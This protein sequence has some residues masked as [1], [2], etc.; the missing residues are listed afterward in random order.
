MTDFRRA[1]RRRLSSLTWSVL[2]FCTVPVALPQGV[3]GTDR[4]IGGVDAG[5]LVDRVNDAMGLR[6]SDVVT[7]KVDA[8][9]GE[10]FQVSLWIGGALRTLDLSPHSVR[11][12]D[13]YQV[14]MQLA[15]GTYAESAPGP[16]RTL[17]GR[18]LG[19]PGSAVAA[20]LMDDGLYA[21][22][23]LGGA[24][25]YWFEP[26]R[27]GLCV[28]CQ[29][30]YV[31]YRDE[32]VLDHGRTCASDSRRP[33]GRF[34]QDPVAEAGGCGGAVCIAEL[35]C[36]ADT[37][38]FNAYGSVAAVEARINLVINAVN[39]QYESQVAISHQITTILVRTSTDPYTLTSPEGRLCQFITEWTNNQTG[40][41]RD[42]AHL[43]TG[44]NI[45]GGVIGIASD[46]GGTGIC[47]NSG[48]CT[49]GT[50]GTHG[51]YCLSQSDFN[52]VF[53][54]A[55]DL[56]THELG[57]LWGAFHCSCPS[58][59]MNPSITCANNFSA[60]SISS[61]TNYR[62]TRTC[63]TAS[64]TPVCGNGII[65]PGEQ[66][67]PPNTPTCTANCQ[68]D[69]NDLC[70]TADPISDGATAFTTIGAG[71]D[72]PSNA[73]CQFDGQTYNDIWYNYTATCTG[74]LTVSLCGS[75]YDTDLV[76]YSGCGCPASNGT[77][78]GCNDDG[79]P[80]AAPDSWRSELPSVDFTQIP[81]VAGSCYKIRVGGWDAGSLGTGTINISCSGTAQCVPPDCSDNNPCTTDACNA[82]VCSH[83]PN[84][85]PCSDGDAC[86]L[87]DACSS[88]VCQPGSPV[89][90]NDGNVCTNDVCVGGSC[91]FAPVSGP[92]NDGDPCTVGEFCQS[93]TCTGGS[94]PDCSGAGDA[95]NTASCGTGGPAGNCDVLTP[96]NEGGPC[97]GTLGVC[98]NGDC[99]LD[100]GATRVY[101]VRPGQPETASLAVGPG[102]TLT[103]EV[104]LEETDL[105]RLGGYQMS[106]PGAA[107]ANGASG[108]V[109]YVDTAGSGGSVLI[110]TGRSDWVYFG[111]P[112]APIPF[113]SE[114]GLPVGFA[115]L[116]SLPLGEGPT[117]TSP[118]YLGEFQFQVS[119]DACGSFTLAFL[120]DGAQPNG[121]SALI[122]ETGLGQVAA[123]YAPL[124]I[125]IGP[126]NDDC[127]D[128]TPLLGNS[129]SI[130][131]DTQCSFQDG[132]LH[133]CGAI[134]SDVWYA[135]TSTCAGQLTVST[136]TGC[137]MDTAIAIYRDGAACTPTNVDLVAC[138]NTVGVCE[139][140]TTPVF[141][142][143]ELL[144]RVGSIA[145]AQGAGTLTVTCVPDAEVTRVFMVRA[146]EEQSA[147]VMAPTLLSMAPGEVVP[148]ELWVDNTDGAR[149]GG[150]QMAIPGAAAPD[151]A[152]GT[153]TYV[154]TL[155]GPGLGGTVLIDVTRPEWVYAADQPIPV[156]S[157]TG[158]PAGFAMIATLPLGEGPL[159]PGLGYLG[160]F[161]FEASTDACGDFTLNFL[162]NGAQPNGGSGLI[163][164]TGLLPIAATYQPLDVVVGPLNEVCADAT[165]ATGFF[166]AD[167]NTLCAVQDGVNHACGA[168]DA[169]I[170]YEYTAS[171]TG[172]LTVDTLSNCAIDTAIA[173]YNP[174]AGCTPSNAN[175]AACADT[176]AACE[177]VVL[178][179]TLG[180]TV[181][182]RVGSIAGAQG[183]GTVTIKCG[184]PCVT[185]N[186][187]GDL[188][189]NGIVDDLCMFYS[190]ESSTCLAAPRIF[191]DAGGPFGDCPPDSFANIHD[192]NHV[193]LCFEGNSPCDTINH[194]VGGQFGECAPDGFCNIHD[195]NHTLSAFSGGNPCVCPANAGPMPEHGP[196]VVASATLSANA[197]RRATRAG[198]EVLVRVFANE[199]LGD[200]QSY[201]L[202]VSVSGGRRGSLE[203][204]DITIED[205]TDYVYAGLTGG[206][207]AFNVTT[208][209]MLNGLG[210]EGAATGSH[211]YLAT[212]RYRA[213]SDARGSFVVDARA[214]RETYLVATGNGKIEVTGTTP[215][216]VVVTP[217]PASEVR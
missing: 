44:A 146:G 168:I 6:A 149:L 36:D 98:Q 205:R 16:V 143:D 56:T 217:Q 133:A 62:N 58:N 152:S 130:P 33:M 92:C 66:C 70:S 142:G 51:S 203:L 137:A 169:D 111:E 170:W 167:F 186:D 206:F 199:A 154:D 207:D 97:N 147:P 84:T 183:P 94:P 52:G 158:L 37:E 46:I 29:D 172:D 119:P 83:I 122:D 177:S 28:T 193:L 14:L 27:S 32:D 145:G 96:S 50:F 163:D 76:I 74:D 64:G 2:C 7:L 5:V 139:A 73:A 1:P 138:A 41:Q 57:H 173:V 216:I 176:P 8:A 54:C 49:G 190:C 61:I 53:A 93:G 20:S 99:I 153:V 79:C 107:T 31:V 100:P 202:D 23:E 164:H 162:P 161:A 26:V 77:M 67:E 87:G 151:G 63:L 175:L 188:D 208:G 157:E 166:T 136:E 128:A 78:L 179:V 171:C 19:M 24:G 182:V 124:D 104:F 150:Y 91:T 47:V 12:P 13:H 134:D 81:V 42:V 48:G 22:I 65:E 68:L 165:P 201:Q 115:F 18:V 82:G 213:S 180:D 80:G 113:Y 35:A 184:P 125:V 105:Q 212:Y 131:F 155:L 121:G 43:F 106:L 189:T 140:I 215:A 120:P 198:G 195:A 38:Y 192:R 60:G 185:G 39:Q 187:C 86:T 210:L 209:Q 10:P 85:L 9:L 4:G 127:A 3:L 101:M 200:L 95:C 89:A 156:Y 129:L 71:T 211:A 135:Y 102:E 181:L 174:G 132:A 123:Y 126:G 15:D 112:S 88:G 116:A 69:I 45:D 197:D 110:D 148:I 103:L 214:D 17:R 204:I 194:D 21:R 40:I 118:V 72:G 90:C 159:V 25:V 141:L 34:L 196:Q 30:A 191:A 59:T 117:V 109:T 144:V 114:S 55:T 75:G 11:S 108:S 160:E 178:P